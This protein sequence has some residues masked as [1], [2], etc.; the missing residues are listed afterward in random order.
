MEMNE[1]GNSRF[2]VFEV[3]P[4]ISAVREWAIVTVAFLCMRRR[5]TG[6]PTVRKN[7]T[8]T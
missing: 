3:V 8:D 7:V 6:M 4:S 5:A 1:V 2:N